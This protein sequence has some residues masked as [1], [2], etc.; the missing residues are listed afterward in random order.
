[1]D[2]HIF[3]IK[4]QEIKELRNTFQ[5]DKLKYD[6]LVEEKIKLENDL[7][8]A[9]NNVNSQINANNTKSP[10]TFPA[11]NFSGQGKFGKIDPKQEKIIM[12]ALSMRIHDL[13]VY[14]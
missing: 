4:I 9:N 3:T 12:E 5:N 2:Y 13:E 8:I 6:Q 11:F 1:M 7:K 14:D 10:Q